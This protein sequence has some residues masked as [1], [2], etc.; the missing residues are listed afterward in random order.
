MRYGMSCLSMTMV[1][2]GEIVRYGRA[3]LTDGGANSDMLMIVLQCD[4]WCDEQDA[5]TSGCRT[6]WS[7]YIRW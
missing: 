6:G 7:G 1:G 3:Q 5:L 4:L 2:W